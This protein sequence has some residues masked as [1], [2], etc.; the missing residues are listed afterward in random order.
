MDK[1]TIFG[2]VFLSVCLLV[3]PGCREKRPE[4]MPDLYPCSVYVI[5]DGK[6]L[7]GA[8]ISFLPVEAGGRWASGGLTDENGKATVRIRGKYKGAAPGKHYLCITKTE[9]D[10]LPSGTQESGKVSVEVDLYDLIDRKFG[11]IET[12]QIVD[13]LE[14]KKNEWTVDVGKAVR[15]LIPKQK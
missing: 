4:G 5:Q 1:K 14:K 15:V 10:P 3:F 2:V 9:S 6:P 13:V 12:A 7:S 11:N 8:S